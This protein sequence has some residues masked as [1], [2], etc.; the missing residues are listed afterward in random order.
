MSLNDIVR[1]RL[2]GDYVTDP[3]GL[4]PELYAAAMRLGR[5]RWRIDAQGLEH[6]PDE[7][8]ALLIVQRHIGVSEQAI[9]STAIS[10]YT[11]RRPRNV[12]VPG[13]G[14]FEAPLRRLGAALAHPDEISGLLRDGHLVSVALAPAFREERPGSVEA[15]LLSPALPIGAPVLPV[16]TRGFEW[17]RRWRVVIDRPLPTPATRGHLAAV[18]LAEGAREAV[19]R[20]QVRE[21]GHAVR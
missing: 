6:I 4:D 19:H 11:R 1:R 16:A 18:E 7:G 17:G 12:G 13:I 10:A 5:M 3:W 21:H 14:L 2:R 9:V 8:P 20:I 15:R